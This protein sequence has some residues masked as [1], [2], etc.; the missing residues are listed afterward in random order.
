M[1]KVY[2]ELFITEICHSDNN[3]KRKLLETEV[4][5]SAE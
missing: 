2:L 4:Y 3:G 5:T 1:D